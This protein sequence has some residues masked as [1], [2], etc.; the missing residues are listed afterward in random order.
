MAW[1]FNPTEESKRPPIFGATPQE[2]KKLVDAS[3]AP[4]P[5]KAYVKAAVD[6]LVRAHG[7]TVLVSVAG[8]G[9][10][11]ERDDDHDLTLAQIEIRKA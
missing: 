5:I 4:D 8:Y 11:C 10:D 7:E 2:A 9:H 6:S 1:T 3:D